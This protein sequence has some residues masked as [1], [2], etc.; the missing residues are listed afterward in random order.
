MSYC[1]VT[2]SCVSLC[3]SVDCSPPGSS[4]HGISQVRI[5]EWGEVSFSRG[6]FLKIGSG[7][8]VFGDVPEEGEG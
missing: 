2:K 8:T 4:V 3:D 1:L 5:L 7:K 6:I